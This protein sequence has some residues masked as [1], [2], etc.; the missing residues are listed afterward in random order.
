MKKKLYWIIGVLLVII[1]VLLV[2]LLLVNRQT[3]NTSIN[4]QTMTPLNSNIS[5]TCTDGTPIGQC[6]ALT[7]TGK[8][9]LVNNVLTLVPDPAECGKGLNFVSWVPIINGGG[10]FAIDPVKNKMY[11]TSNTFL[12]ED[13]S[14]KAAP[15][16]IGHII[17]LEPGSPGAIAING[18]YA[19]VSWGKGKIRIVDITGDT[20]IYVTKPIQLRQNALYNLSNFYLE[21]PN[22]YMLEDLKEKNYFH[23]LNVD[24]SD[25]NKPTITGDID[26]NKIYN[27]KVDGVGRQYYIKEENYVYMTFKSIQNLNQA[28]LAIIDITN[29]VQPLV[30]KLDLGQFVTNSGDPGPYGPAPHIAKRGNYLYITG[31]FSSPA[32][33]L[34]I[35]NIVNPKSPNLAHSWYKGPDGRDEYYADIDISGNYAYVSTLYYSQI[36]P[37]VGPWNGDVR[38]LD[39]TDPLNPVQKGVVGS[40]GQGKPWDVKAVGTDIYLKQWDDEYDYIVDASN[41]NRPYLK[42][43]VLLGH[44]LTNMDVEGDFLYYIM[45]DQYQFNVVD[46]SNKQ[47]PVIVTRNKDAWGKGFGIF[48]KDKIAYLGMSSAYPKCDPPCGGLWT[49]DIANPQN[50]TKK[51]ALTAISSEVGDSNVF[52]DDRRIAY[53]TSGMPNDPGTHWGFRTIDVADPSNPKE[54]DRYDLDGSKG[55]AVYASG[56]YAYLSYGDEGLYIMDVTDPSKIILKTQWK[57]PDFPQNIYVKS[58]I[59]VDDYAYVCDNNQFKI[60]NIQNK[61]SPDKIGYYNFSNCNGVKVIG[62][63]A[64]VVGGDGVK[65]LDVRDKTAPVEVA[66]K[67]GIFLSDLNYIDVQGN[68]IYAMP[69]NGGAYILHWGGI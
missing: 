40:F 54:L 2:F 33:S 14:N 8:C 63:N 60:L 27:P 4:N 64:Y 44:G 28:K 43:I 12:V 7:V 61:Q 35:V 62:N 20:P 17:P 52:V 39:I 41:P 66:A 68:Y 38:V 25:I 49:F 22:L 24:V 15:T 57:D 48:V 23:F 13:I 29:H 6:S 50:P 36:T 46:I 58:A 42:G 21:Y 31:I 19:Y 53:T 11:I 51:G 16:E 30:S 18:N 69:F 34:K 65:I 32:S 5:S 9:E 1:I 47:D 59:I 67:Q 10:G 3:L 26:L 56:N 45:W 37:P 55:R